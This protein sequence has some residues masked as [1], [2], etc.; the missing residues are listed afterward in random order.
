MQTRR[1]GNDWVSPIGL[2]TVKIGRNQQVKYPQAF[3]IPDDR[4]VK[5]LFDTALDLGVNLIDTAP[6]YGCSEERLGRLLPGRRH[7]W[8]VM[9]KVGEEFEHGE[10]YFDFSEQHI[11]WSIERSLQRLQ[12]DY[13]DTVLV[14]STGADVELIQRHGV[15]DILSDIKTKGLI[16]YYGMSTK[17]VEGGLLALEKSDVLMV[18]YNL[19]HTEE[20]IILDKAV[21][22][23]KSILIKKAFASGY[24]C[25]P[26]AIQ[27]TFEKIYSFPA[28]SSVIVGTTNP[29]HLRENIRIMSLV[30]TKG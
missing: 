3:D 1:L 9:T 20:A 12:T 27:E 30:K 18:T 23:D 28:V 16:R 17:T 26:A 6:A 4:A 11:R 13:L 25:S 24:V 5:E 2:G 7:D 29:K 8:H 10:S 15:L 14:H 22:L 21:S 19:Q